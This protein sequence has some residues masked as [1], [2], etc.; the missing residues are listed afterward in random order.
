MS[1]EHP[2]FPASLRL[3]V[4]DDHPVVREGLALLLDHRPNLKVIAQAANGQEAVEL[5]RQECP[6]VVILDLQ[7]PVMNGAVASERILKEDPNAKI[8]LLT[9]FDGDEDIL[10]G[11]RA[12][13][14]GYLLKD[15][16]TE[17]LI[18]A[19]LLVHQGGKVLSNRAGLKLSERMA[20]GNLTQRETEVLRL[21]A[22]G[23]S[24]K[25]IGSQLGV[26]EGTVKSHLNSI[27]GKLSVT[28]RTEAALVARDRGFFRD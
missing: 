17:E 21:V 28:S 1:S 14:K 25:Q 16:P 6:D 15:T 26:S 11:L 4:A 3:L 10:R 9:T 7:M 13:A 20:F 27:M 2:D 5:Y 22:D 12:G 23:K 8:L 19:I 18:A 24:N